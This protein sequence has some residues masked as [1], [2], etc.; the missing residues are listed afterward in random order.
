MDTSCDLADAVTAVEAIGRLHV[1]VT[2]RVVTLDHSTAASDVR[3]NVL[4]LPATEAQ[5]AAVHVQPLVI[6]S[7]LHT[8]VEGSGPEFDTSTTD[9]S[10]IVINIIVDGLLTSHNREILQANC[11]HHV[12][13]QPYPV[14][15]AVMLSNDSSVRGM[16][17]TSWCCEHT[18]E[19]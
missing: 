4:S 15:F 7:R 11:T 17:K 19:S 14:K 8:D 1:P 18:V 13:L 9:R 16:A 5:V 3:Q 10:I 12:K 2:A 6:I